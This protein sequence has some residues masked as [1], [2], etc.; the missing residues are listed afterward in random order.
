[1]G[2]SCFDGGDVCDDVTYETNIT[3]KNS[4]PEELDDFNVDDYNTD[5]YYCL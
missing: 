2:I 4:L 1:M 5:D 3:K